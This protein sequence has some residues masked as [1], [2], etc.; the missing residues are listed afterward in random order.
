M[1]KLYSI[2][3]ALLLS[4]SS[5]N[6]QTTLSTAVDFTVTDTKGGTHNLFSLLN[7]G[8]YV[9]LDFF[10]KTCVPCQGASPKFKTAYQN[11]GCNTQD[12]IFMSIDMGD[13]NA[14]VDAY[15]TS[16]LGGNAGFP[17]ISGTQGGGNAVVT[18]YGIGAFPTF[19]LIAPNKQILEKDMWP[20]NTAAD[21]DTYF[22]PHSLTQKPCITGINNPETASPVNFHS[23]PNPASGVLNIS[24][25][26]GKL[27]GYKIYDVVGKQYFKAPFKNESKDE[28]SLDGLNP[29]MYFIE[30]ETSE[31]K[32]VK[33][34][35]KE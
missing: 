6:A 16:F 20:I 8:K 10:F 25:E 31:G 9:C 11:Y 30:V 27:M 23:Y 12:V 2:L 14:D 4:I 32:A 29:G 34:F 19:I 7:S 13:S 33:T 26:T 15:E 1:R 28:I 21:F 24:L 35:I 3:S 22:S 5:L 18:A 17:A